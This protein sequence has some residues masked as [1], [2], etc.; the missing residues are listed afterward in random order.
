M[1]FVVTG[2]S[3]IYSVYS[4]FNLKVN[5]DNLINDKWKKNK[6]FINIIENK[7]VKAISLNTYE[8]KIDFPMYVGVGK[9]G[10]IGIPIGGRNYEE[11]KEIYNKFS[12]GECNLENWEYLDDYDQEYFINTPD[13]LRDCLNNNDINERSLMIKLPIKVKHSKLSNI[14][15]T[16]FKTPL[17]A[18]ENYLVSSNVN[19]LIKVAT[20]RK[21]MPL[22]ITSGIICMIGIGYIFLNTKNTKY[23]F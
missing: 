16:K 17:F 21:R 20:I 5:K 18:Q 6:E 2:L 11:C 22:S 4:L 9:N 10:S 1:E 23:I 19:N 8:N 13:S 14:Y 7:D 12:N 15:Y 3:G